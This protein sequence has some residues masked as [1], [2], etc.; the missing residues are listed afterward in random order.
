MRSF[1]QAVLFVFLLCIVSAASTKYRTLA[2][3][4][5]VQVEALPGVP[6]WHLFPHLWSYNAVD[7]SCPDQQDFDVFFANDEEILLDKVSNGDTA[8][9]GMERLL[10][11]HRHKC[12]IS[13]TP[14]QTTQVGVVP[15]RG[16]ILFAAGKANCNLRTSEQL[17]VP[18]IIAGIV[19]VALFFNAGL[20]SQSL[21]FRITT[22]SVTF[23]LLAVVMLVFVL[24]RMTPNKKSMAAVFA[25]FGSSV[26]GLVRY[27]FGRW[28]P[29]W[30]QLV[31]N[32]LAWAYVFLSGLSG[33]AL[34]YYY[35]DEG[36]VKLLNILK[37]GLMLVGLGLVFFSTSMTE[38]SATLCVLLLASLPASVIWDKRQQR[39]KDTWAGVKEASKQHLQQF[40]EETVLQAALDMSPRQDAFTQKREPQP[41]FSQTPGSAKPRQAST[42][43]WRHPAS[44]TPLPGEYEA[45]TPPAPQ[46]SAQSPLLTPKHQAPA[47]DNV[48]PLVQRGYILNEMTGRTI[49]LNSA[50]YNKLVAN[51]HVVDRK[52]GV[53]TPPSKAGNESD[54]TDIDQQPSSTPSRSAK[55]RL[56]SGRACRE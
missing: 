37:Y 36:N 14:F 31:Y 11:G 26:S 24:A 30:Q 27:L 16:R 46:S 50:T 41:A 5:V 20:L 32:K 4:T 45:S 25:V 13:I 29:S 34:T 42:S 21:S 10:S 3:G 35:D 8:W 51:G 43:G 39:I 12:S 52:N 55:S 44:D 7:V 47:Q 33:A 18:L 54:D 56:S 9:C 1:G 49:K 53:L 17:S 2:D 23:M 15:S 6:K 40:Q 38:A 19:G 48:S 28:I 22:G